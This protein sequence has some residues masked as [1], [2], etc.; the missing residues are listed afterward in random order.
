MNNALNNLTVSIITILG[1]I[2][3]SSV[4][5]TVISVPDVNNKTISQAI[6][7]AKSGDT[8]IVENGIYSEEIFV[9]SGITLKAKSLFNAVIKGNGKGNIVIMGGNAIISGFEIRD[10]AIGITSKTSDNSILNCRIT[11]MT[12]SGIS[13]VGQLPK[14]QN[15][16]IVYNKGSGIQG[17]D[18]RSTF[19]SIIHNTIAFNLNNGIALGGK[20][21]VI[22]EN[23]IVAFNERFGIKVNEETVTVQLVKNV[24]FE[25]TSMSF[26]KMDNNAT[27][28]PMF[29]APKKMNF[30][31]QASSQCKDRASDNKDVGALNDY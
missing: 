25:N 13:C 1:C 27:C 7:N 30:R 17:W 22:M 28:D 3:A 19:S 8:V 23:N 21:T 18:V 20:S 31:L 5:A 29:V 6:S 14:I 12:L 11:A 4:S 16:I 26:I 9:K 10:G 15:N 24:F 2:S